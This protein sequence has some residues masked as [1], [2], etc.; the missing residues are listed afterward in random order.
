MIKVQLKP[1]FTEYEIRS[2][3]GMQV[4]GTHRVT[5]PD[6]SRIVDMDV[7]FPSVSV[8]QPQAS[9]LT[10]LAVRIDPSDG[11]K[12]Q[13]SLALKNAMKA[14]EA[15]GLSQVKIG[16]KYDVSPCLVRK[17]LGGETPTFDFDGVTAEDNSN[18]VA[19]RQNEVSGLTLPL[20]PFKKLKA[21]TRIPDEAR[22][23]LRKCYSAGKYMVKD[24]AKAFGVKDTT[25][26]FFCQDLHSE[27][28][29][30]MQKIAEAK[31]AEV[32]E[33]HT[34]PPVPVG[35]PVTVNA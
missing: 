17:V 20:K 28:E 19:S 34:L 6:T 7:T 27:R 10:K 30:N 8:P 22:E 3:D 5:L 14:D 33:F 11:R 18:T 4:L 1:L 26:C 2:A 21:R 32:K 23:W 25:V 31:K 16:Q 12:K 15:N 35:A 24:I 9:T 13:V 29:K